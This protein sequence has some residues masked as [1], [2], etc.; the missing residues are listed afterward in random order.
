MRHAAE[1]QRRANKLSG[2][3][4]TGM[5]TQERE[6][7]IKKGEGWGRVS[8]KERGGRTK[9]IPSGWIGTYSGW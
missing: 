4:R 3:Q 8:K 2:V 1:E 9:K 7:G 5:H 6:K